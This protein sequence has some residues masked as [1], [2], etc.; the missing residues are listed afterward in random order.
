MQNFFIKNFP[1]FVLFFFPVSILL[2]SAVLNLYLVIASLLFIFWSYKKKYFLFSLKNNWVWFYLII[3]A[4]LILI[5]LFSTNI[6]P[7]LKS[8]LS[9]LRFIF[10]V[11]FLGCISFTEDNIK[12]FI[13]YTSILILLICFD[14]LLQYFNGKDLFTFEAARYADIPVRLSGPFGDE[15]IVGTFIAFIAIPI[16]SY[17]FYNFSKFSKSEKLHNIIFTAICFFT[18][19][20]SGERIAFLIFASSLLI[21]VLINFGIKKSFFFSLI[22]LATVFFFIQNN[23]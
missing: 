5:S 4:Y 9:Q 18:V 12:K 19:L 17:F 14:T 13:R 23:K 6:S 22:F 10:F 8:A 20:L 11:L 1:F 21:I 15:L 7:S 3:I 16:I 2:R